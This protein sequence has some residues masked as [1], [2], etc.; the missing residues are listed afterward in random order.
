MNLALLKMISNFFP[1]FTLNCEKYLCS[2]PWHFQTILNIFSVV[3]TEMNPIC[4]N[5]Y[6]S[7]VK[8]TLSA[9]DLASIGVHCRTPALTSCIVLSSSLL[10][11]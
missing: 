7:T 6:T 1:Y 4:S 8:C 5:Q 10:V 3:K 11:E 2:T 9:L